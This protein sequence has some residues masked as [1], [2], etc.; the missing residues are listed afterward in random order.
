MTPRSAQ[1][2]EPFCWCCGRDKPETELVRL[3]SHP[4][5]GVC[6]ECARWLQRRA[7]QRH[8]SRHPGPSARLR[9]GIDAG[10]D[11]VIRKGWHRRGLLGALLRRIDRYLP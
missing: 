3:G 2:T 5:V 6:L 1:D 7:R 9:G 10:R 11:L 8:D 4:E